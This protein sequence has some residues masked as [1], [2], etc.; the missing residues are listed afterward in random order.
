MHIW[1]CS[2]KTGFPFQHFICNLHER[3]AKRIKF[4]KRAQELGFTLNEIKELLSLQAQP[5]ADRAEVKQ[6]TERK[7]TD[8][9]NRIRDLVRM[10]E[11]LIEI[12]QTCDGHGPTRDCPILQ[13]FEQPLAP[14][15]HPNKNEEKS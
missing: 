2:G 8:I 15:C 3:D 14:A 13:A 9:E 1:K 7:I 11:T 12:A 6:A 10:K 5:E 4:I